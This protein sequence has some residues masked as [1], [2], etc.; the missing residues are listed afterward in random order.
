M[1]GFSFRSKDFKHEI[2]QTSVRSTPSPLKMLTFVREIT[3]VFVEIV[4]NHKYKVRENF[5]SCHDKARGTVITVLQSEGR[6]YII[7]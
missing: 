3:A 6:C 4:R 2:V 1:L 5:Q 7:G